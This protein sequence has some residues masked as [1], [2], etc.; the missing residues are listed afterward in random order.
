MAVLP[1]AGYPRELGQAFRM[2]GSGWEIGTQALVQIHVSINTP[3]AG[4][5]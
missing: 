4:G 3:E 1:D 2:D 5:R